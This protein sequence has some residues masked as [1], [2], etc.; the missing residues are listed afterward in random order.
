[1]STEKSSYSEKRGFIRMNI[2]EGTLVTLF[3]NGEHIQGECKNLSGSG[4]LVL[5][6]NALE[7]GSTLEAEINSTY[8]HS[9]RLRAKAQV[10]R[11]DA[12]EGRYASGLEILEILP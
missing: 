1:M 4:L 9:P 7:A 10:I 2:P 8:G 11:S 3:V 6:A 12:T 5:T